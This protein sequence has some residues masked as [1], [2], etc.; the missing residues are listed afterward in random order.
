MLRQLAWIVYDKFFSTV[1]NCGQCHTGCITGGQFPTCI[2]PISRD[3]QNIAKMIYRYILEFWTIYLLSRL[4]VIGNDHDTLEWLVLLSG[5]TWVV[6]AIKRPLADAPAGTTCT[7]PDSSTNHDSTDRIS[8][9]FLFYHD[10]HFIKS[11]ENLRFRRLASLFVPIGV[12]VMTHNDGT[13]SDVTIG[14]WLHNGPLARYAKLRL[15]MRRECWK[16]FP[17]RSAFAIPTWITARAWRTCRD[18]CQDR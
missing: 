16:R 4:L 10:H 9:Q 13:A 7:V 14:V 18:A 11:K 15:H 3:D 17:R 12:C 8:G 1:S 2:M 6:L 5:T